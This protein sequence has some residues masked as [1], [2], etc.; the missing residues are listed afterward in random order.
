MPSRGHA[1]PRRGISVS[2]RWGWGPSASE[3]KLAASVTKKNTALTLLLAGLF[4]FSA[5]P[6]PASAQVPFEQA[7]RDLGSADAATR[8]RTVQMLK[9]AAY[10]ESAAPLARLIVDS[11]DSVQLEAIAAELN[12]F[13]AEKIVPRK[14]VGFIVELRTP[15]AADAIFTTGPLAVGP[16][17]V[18]LEVLDALRTAA[19][20]DNPR[21]R[22]EAMYAFGVLAVEP[23]GDRR[24]ELLRTSGPDVAAMIGAV[25]PAHRYAALQVIGRVFE[26]RLHDE[27]IEQNLGDAVISALNEKEPALQ[28]AAM[29]ALGAMRYERAVQGLMDLFQYHGKGD[30][31]ES[32]LDAIA[33]IAHPSSVPLLVAQLASKNAALKGM[34]IEGLARAGDRTRLGDVQSATRTD[35]N[36]SLQL[37]GSFASVMLSGDAAGGGMA[38]IVEEL[39][40]PRLREQAR[41]YLIEAAPGRTQTFTRFL[42][43][44]DPL[45]RTALVDALGLSGD[46]AAI[47]LVQPMASD[48]DVQVARAVERALAR[49]RQV[50]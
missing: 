47:A 22:L 45:V 17:P 33:H 14:R 4:C 19:R 38:P 37:A 7:L 35:R 1:K 13:I 27:A 18:P 46:S 21:V 32:V 36:G 2:S 44:P 6:A 40:N 50:K 29:E 31:A 25:D 10:P 3:R 48:K 16:R 34:A 23:G 30:M 15:V 20:D 11:Q 26:R 24:R 49:L 28:A 39:A 41:W 9:E 12:I 5:H 43:D 8:L 42:Q